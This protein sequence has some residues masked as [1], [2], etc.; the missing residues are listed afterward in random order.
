M[1]STAPRVIRVIE[2]LQAGASG[3]GCVAAAAMHGDA[4]STQTVASAVTAASATRRMNVLALP[5]AYTASVCMHGHDF[6]ATATASACASAV[7]SAIAVA[8]AAHGQRRCVK[9]SRPLFCM[10]ALYSRSAAARADRH[11]SYQVLSGSTESMA[12]R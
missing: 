10:A 7:A 2:T 11:H 5:N 1:A 4:P 8:D 3:Q 6:V 9:A 12:A